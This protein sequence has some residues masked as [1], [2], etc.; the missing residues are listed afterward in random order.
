MLIVT[1]LDDVGLLGDSNLTDAFRQAVQ[2]DCAELLDEGE[3][4]SVVK[5]CVLQPDVDDCLNV[6][7]G[8]EGGWPEW[9]EKVELSDG[10]AAYKVCMM[11]DNDCFTIVW[12][13]ASVDR[14]LDEWLSDRCEE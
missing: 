11:T 2:S 9:A 1:E 6:L 10:T 14:A 8:R 3:G 12:A 5:V 7:Q 13:P 4:G